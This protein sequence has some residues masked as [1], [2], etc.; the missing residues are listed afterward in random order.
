MQASAKPGSKPVTVAPKGCSS[1]AGQHDKDQ[2]WVLEYIEKK[3][4]KEDWGKLEKRKVTTRLNTDK[5][6]QVFHCFANAVVTRSTEPRV[7]HLAGRILYDVCP[8]RW[9]THIMSDVFNGRP[10]APCPRTNCPCHG[11]NKCVRSHGWVALPR[12]FTGMNQVAYV[13]ASSFKCYGSKFSSVL[14][15]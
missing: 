4:W 5:W 8:A 7:H 6:P 10:Y 2:P 3:G 14:R 1:N 11:T 13:Y 9:F 12:K 15:D